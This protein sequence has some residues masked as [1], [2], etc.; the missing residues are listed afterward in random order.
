M[1]GWFVV[2]VAA[3][4][5]PMSVLKSATYQE[6][7]YTL[8]GNTDTSNQKLPTIVELVCQRLAQDYQICTT[9]MEGVTGHTLS[10]AQLQNTKRISFCLSFCNQFHKITYEEGTEAIQVDRW[11]RRIA[12]GTV[13]PQ[14]HNIG[15]H[16][17]AEGSH[18]SRRR[19][20]VSSEKAGLSVALPL[21][22]G[23]KYFIWSDLN[24]RYV[25]TKRDILPTHDIFSFN[26]NE[27]DQV[28]TGLLD[29]EEAASNFKFRT[30]RFGFLTDAP[31]D[32]LPAA[33]GE[34]RT[35]KGADK[36]EKS[37][38]LEAFHSLIQAIFKKS[39]EE[40]NITIHN[41]PLLL[42][43]FPRESVVAMTDFT[44]S[45]NISTSGLEGKLF[46][47]TKTRRTSVKYPLTARASMRDEWIFIRYDT[48]YHDS[49]MY[50]I[51]ISWL[52]ASGGYVLE[53][54]NKL[55]K[56]RVEQLMTVESLGISNSFRVPVLIRMT[57]AATTAAALLSNLFSKFGF[58]RDSGSAGSTQFIHHLGFVF[59]CVRDDGILWVGNA[60]EG[61]SASRKTQRNLFVLF[62]DFCHS[63][64]VATSILS[65]I[66]DN[67]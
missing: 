30:I 33:I 45:P 65:R 35:T 49:V 29:E 22:L 54:V 14:K 13:L 25:A 60:L 18:P 32:C 37:T 3:Y 55:T 31:A 50:R 24:S 8:T 9:P 15:M 36:G 53:W 61:V 62:R 67:I 23:Y 66:I 38:R 58:V 63:V 7:T 56:K 43:K 59:L 10:I 28:C 48:D 44:H 51:D 6:Y 17:E 42:H 11:I 64:S 39:P 40:M 52:V 4:F 57:P 20:V 41:E 34:I 2:V 46:D 26:W 21:A 5:P 1:D 19:N 47:V 27:C 16:T 12:A